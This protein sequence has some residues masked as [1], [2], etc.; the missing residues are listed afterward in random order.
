M[1]SDEKPIE[2]LSSTIILLKKD[3]GPDSVQNPPSEIPRVANN[4]IIVTGIMVFLAPKTSSN[5]TK[6][7]SE[8]IAISVFIFFIL[9][10][11][12][13]I[14]EYLPQ[15]LSGFVLFQFL[16]E[17]A[18]TLHILFQTFPMP[19]RGLFFLRVKAILFR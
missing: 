6:I 15:F 13:L 11:S 10:C 5:N 19:F 3:A 4:P 2:Y 17:S 8:P 9:S 12:V 7:P 16:S 18:D 14:S 1:K